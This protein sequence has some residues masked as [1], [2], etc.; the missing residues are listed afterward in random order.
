[1]TRR[2]LS[3]VAVLLCLPGWLLA[4]QPAQAPPA[5][6]LRGFRTIFV[7]SETIYM[8]SEFLQRALSEQREFEL[9]KLK[10]VLDP[11]EAD[12]VLKVQRPFLTFDWNY[13][14]AERSGR[15][16]LS[17]YVVASEGHRAAGRIAE[18]IIKRLAPVR[19]SDTRPPADVLRTFRTLYLESHT[20]YLKSDEIHSAL[21]QLV[22]LSTWGVEL[23]PEQKGAD[24]VITI[25][26]PFLTYDWE[27][28]IYHPASGRQIGNG[29][30]VAWDG[31]E[32]APLLAAAIGN[33]LGSARAGG[34]SRE[35]APRL[36]AA[37][38]QAHQWKAVLQSG[39]GLQPGTALTV[40]VVGGMMVGVEGQRV[41]FSVPA[42][43][44]V[45]VTY[46][47]SVKDVPRAWWT[48]R[49]PSAAG[50]GSLI[51]VPAAQA[52][53]QPP[54]G[55][56]T[57]YVT[58][59]W[60]DS[61]RL[62]ELQLQLKPSDCQ[63]LLAELR[64][65]TGKD[66]TSASQQ[67]SALRQRLERERGHAVVVEFDRPIR[68]GW[69]EVAAGAYRALVLERESRRGEF[70]LFADAELNRMLAQAIVELAERP[71]SSSTVQVTYKEENGIVTLA[72]IR[73]GARTVRFTAV[74]VPVAQ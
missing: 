37:T 16:L 30:I 71:G 11:A 15:E 9:W 64:T 45:A 51:L 40:A 33:H 18:E 49:D 55:G 63:S 26:R 6:H 34:E 29:T 28:R 50:R 47:E 44:M 19:A 68:V 54:S 42:A 60:Q 41:A 74:P 70:Y 52:G 32:A 31:P 20:V 69:T 61:G 23:V 57:H 48:V 35:P 1:M 43:D 10:F 58:I 38:D 65:A 66:W 59:A 56:E 46:D 72:E 67:A 7:K 27:Y 21:R 62:R 36:P 12:V 73:M 13:Q 3:I 14:L 5:D 25:H 39:Y 8:K 2:Y 17:G 24:L 4:Q 22:P 53:G